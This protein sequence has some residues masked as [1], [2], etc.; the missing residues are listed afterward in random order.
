MESALAVHVLVLLALLQVKHFICDGPLQTAS[1]VRDKGHYG[2][3]LG[4]SHA[5]IHGLGTALALFIGG[6]SWRTAI[7]LAVLDVVLHYHID[8]FKEQA[9]RRAGWTVSTAQ[10]WWSLSAD[11]ALH[12]MTYLGLAW[13]ALISV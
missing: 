9:V 1:M 5:G 10:F 11:Q 8:F 2:R 6:L 3:W 12:Q 4:I 13:L 7:G